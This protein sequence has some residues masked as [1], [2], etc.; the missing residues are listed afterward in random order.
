MYW[1]TRALVET[2]DTRG[3]PKLLPRPR[4]F[5]FFATHHMFV[6]SLGHAKAFLHHSQYVYFF[7]YLFPICIRCQTQAISKVSNRV[8]WRC[9]RET[10][11]TTVCQVR[12]KR[13]G[14]LIKDEPRVWECR[15]FSSDASHCMTNKSKRLPQAV[16][17]DKMKCLLNTDEGNNS[18]RCVSCT[19]TPDVHHISLIFSVVFVSCSD[20]R[21]FSLCFKQ[22]MWD[23]CTYLH[24]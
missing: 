5:F 11:D 17:R 7:S 12:D 19:A 10:F 13:R 16:R 15:G 9:A 4:L 14:L 21:I 20:N 23:V 6:F 24:V 22:L 2:L 3:T 1:K 8:R 18:C